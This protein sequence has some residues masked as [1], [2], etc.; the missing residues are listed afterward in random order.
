MLIKHFS[1]RTKLFIAFLLACFISLGAIILIFKYT[2][3]DAFLDYIEQQDKAQLDRLEQSLLEHYATQLSWDA[4]R[5][6]IGSLAPFIIR[7]QPPPSN[8]PPEILLED[9]FSPAKRKPPHHSRPPFGRNGRFFARVLIL[10]QNRE[11]VYSRPEFM[12]RPHSLE[13]PL[14]YQGRIIG[15]V[16][17]YRS[18]E[19]LDQLDR[20]FTHRLDYLLWLA[21]IAALLTTALFSFLMTR[22]LVKPIDQLRHAT[23]RL[24]EGQYGLQ[25]AVKSQDEL[26]K[27]TSDFN[28][29]SERLK[30]NEGARKQW[31]MDIAHELRTP[32]AILRG[33]IEALQDGI[34]EP[35]EATINSLHQEVLHL[36][37]LVDDLYTLSM[38]DSGALSYHK[39][40]L[41]ISSLLTETLNQF[42]KVLAD[43]HITLTTTIRQPP[44]IV[45]GDEQ[46]LQQLFQNLI[47]NTQRY[48][49]SPGQLQV[50]LQTTSKEVLIQ[51]SDS[52]PGVPDEALP[53][54]FERLYRVEGSRN[55]ATGGAGIGLSIS[56][57][58]V[59]AHHGSIQASH[60]PLGG[61]AIT[62]TLPLYKG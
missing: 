10:D 52:A 14:A 16:G 48:T 22:Q 20:E 9:M 56:Y 28:Q 30:E 59:H 47:K 18:V 35:D 6:N 2:V 34:N 26:G 24:T 27:L 11:M 45:H 57:N 60:S 21:A 37:R 39:I 58:I 53:K 50:R 41:D 51:F 15:Y 40:P 62:I 31:I 23:T 13:R 1:I 29:L 17:M 43:Q 7:N 61:L 12:G 42:Q 44:V 8:P 46:R 36:N 4:L 38:S 19:F 3:T 55:R 54:L 5:T 32:L 25:M 33:E 49:D